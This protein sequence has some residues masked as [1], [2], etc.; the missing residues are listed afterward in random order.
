MN[1]KDIVRSWKDE[2][3]RY[4]LKAPGDPAGPVAIGDEEL[5][6]VSGTDPLL[7]T[8]I[9]SIPTLLWIPPITLP[10]VCLFPR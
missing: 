10:T 6:E 4:S 8:V 2:D 7:S 1:P 3:Y 9:I 5:S